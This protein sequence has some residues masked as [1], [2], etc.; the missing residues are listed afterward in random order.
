[1]DRL[2]KQKVNEISIAFNDALDQMDL[3]DIF[4]A[5]H[6]KQQNTHSS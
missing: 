6:L 2:S 5:F 4:R 3:T 1:M